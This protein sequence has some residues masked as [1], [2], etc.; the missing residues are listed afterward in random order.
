MANANYRAGARLERL[1]INQMKRQGYQTMRSAGSKG[2]IDCIAWNDQ[3][4]IMVQVKNGRAAYTSA[5]VEKLREMSRPPGTKVYL[6][7]RDGGT[8]DWNFI[9]C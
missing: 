6:A 9:E 8:V 2:L 1:W 5:D 7:E 4:I 3:E